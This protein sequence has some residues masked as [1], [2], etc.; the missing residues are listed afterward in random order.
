[1]RAFQFIYGPRVL[2]GT[3]GA[4]R[5]GDLLPDGPCLF[6]TDDDIIR[7]GLAEPW[8]AALRDKPRREPVQ[9]GRGRSVE[10]DFARRG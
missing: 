8:L 3:D 10:G 7:L 2:S 5:L 6:V 4:A 1:M 9:R